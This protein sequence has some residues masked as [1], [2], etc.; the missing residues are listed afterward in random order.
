L[1]KAGKIQDRRLPF[2][3]SETGRVRFLLPKGLTLGN[4]KDRVPEKP[5]AEFNRR[6]RIDP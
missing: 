6:A 5:Q 4:R 2:T 3:M 1:E